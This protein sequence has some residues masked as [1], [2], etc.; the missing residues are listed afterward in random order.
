MKVPGKAC[1]DLMVL[2]DVFPQVH[3]FLMAQTKVLLPTHKWSI[4]MEKEENGP[5]RRGDGPVRL[6]DIRVSAGREDGTVTLCVLRA[7]VL[8][9]NCSADFSRP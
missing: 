9:H 2:E 5:L 6:M 3:P 7:T 1:Q 4:K 8:S